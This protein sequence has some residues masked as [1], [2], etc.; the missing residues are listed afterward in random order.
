YSEVVTSGNE[1]RF[2]L[3]LDHFGRWCEVTAFAR[4]P[5]HL[6]T[7]LEDIS[8]RKEAEETL[9][10]KATPLERSNAELEQFA[11]VAS[12]DLQEPLRMVASYT[13]LLA[14]RYE[15]KLDE[16]AH[17]YIGYAVDGA[18]RMQALIND[19]LSFSR[20]G[21]KGKKPLGVDSSDVL[22][23]VIRNL[24]RTIS[25]SGTELEVGDMPSVLADRTQLGQVF[26][27]LIAN[28]I[29]FRGSEPP[30]IRITSE[31]RDGLWAI[32]VDDNGLGI[33]EQFYDRI[34]VIFQRLHGRG[35]YEGNGMGLAIVK[36][37]VERH[38]GYVRIEPKNGSGTRFTFTMPAVN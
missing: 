6:V 12:H 28:A 18:K 5:G 17:K 7:M 21:T 31:Q 14:D 26:Q 22:A 2:E 9:R 25:D 32:H 29:K 33:E 16:K 27:N 23:E 19:L 24:E 30:K 20:V 36:K 10:I 1:K 15:S 37:I 11:Y 35:E 13:Q 4:R 34:F 8:V 3:V 38:G